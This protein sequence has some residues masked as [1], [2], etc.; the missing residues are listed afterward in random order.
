MKESFQNNVYTVPS[1]NIG[2]LDKYEQ[3]R[4]WNKSALFILLIFHS[5]NSQNSNLIIEVKQLKVGRK[6]Q[7]EINVFL[8]WMLATII[9]TP[10][11][12]YE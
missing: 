7:D 11:N 12:S 6:S 4:L 1:T 2:T 10:R 3:R 5:I 8:Q 9:V